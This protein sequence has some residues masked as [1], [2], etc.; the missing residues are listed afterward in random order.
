MDEQ[1][2]KS[3]R[4]RPLGKVEAKRGTRAKDAQILRAAVAMLGMTAT[5]DCNRF[6]VTRQTFSKWL[7]GETSAPRDVYV[8]LLDMVIE[9]AANGTGNLTAAAEARLEKAIDER[10]AAALK[11][12]AR[13]KLD[14]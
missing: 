13:M 6:N 1:K 5:H 10:I 9:A 7:R 3:R 14:D 4:G 11:I 2:P 8:A 12:M